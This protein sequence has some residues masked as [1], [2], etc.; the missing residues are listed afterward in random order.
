MSP[1]HVTKPPLFYGWI[2]VASSFTILFVSFG[3]AY[4][5]TTFIEPLQAE[6]GASRGALSLAF[7]CAGAL[8]FV[9]GA[10]GGPLADRLG[11]RWV[12]L[13]GI[14]LLGSGYFV[15][16]TAA[17][18]WQVYLG[19]GLG[20][21]LGIGLVYTPAVGAVQP[22]FVRRRGLTTGIAI[23]G[24]GVG[25]LCAAPAAAWLIHTAGWRSAY[26]GLVAIVLVPGIIAALAIDSTPHKRGLAP[27]GATGPSAPAVEP[28]TSLRDALRSRTFWL[29]Y[30]TN[31]T[32]SIG[33]LVPFLHLVPFAQDAGID[34]AV[35]VSLF[36]LLGLGSAV[37]RFLIGGLADR[38]G[39]NRALTAMCASL[40]T[41]Y[42]WW[43]LSS[44]AWQLAIFAAFFGTFYGGF[45]ALLP[46]AVAD[47]FGARNISGIIG[48]LYT[49]VA[50]GFLLGPTLAGLAFDIWQSYTLPIVGCLVVT[51]IAT[52]FARLLQHQ[53]RATAPNSGQN[54]RKTLS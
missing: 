49:S 30:G 43:L 20:V 17:Q 34:R 45:V 5:F 8:Y 47:H 7:A 31:A 51:V 44:T 9:V 26:F 35:A 52:N 1:P 18:L 38:I 14:L 21:G 32:L 29:L 3:S 4:S 48:L 42:A 28:G 39:R 54:K 33:L 23:S 41:I 36:V 22:W 6:F 19:Y 24:I 2:V 11:H 25:T 16:A 37:G 15:A 13:T 46:T 50:P 10:F 53:D 27:D 12:I 40:I